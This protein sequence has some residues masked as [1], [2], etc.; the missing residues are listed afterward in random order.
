M[1]KTTELSAHQ[2]WQEQLAVVAAEQE[3][4][5][6]TRYGPG[7]FGCHELL[8]RVL[9][10]GDLVEGQV[11]EHPACVLRRV[12]S[13]CHP[14][15]GSVA[16]VV[17]ADRGRA[18]SNCGSQQRWHCPDNWIGLICI[19]IIN[20]THP[21]SHPPRAPKHRPIQAVAQFQILRNT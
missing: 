15:G 9:L 6:E 1:D 20:S 2:E 11:L 8:D 4:G 17:P 10:L 3:P 16:G 13:S 21:K 12:A 14:S 7:S 19:L 18:S 5:W